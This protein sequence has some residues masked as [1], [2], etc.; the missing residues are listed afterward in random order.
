MFGSS[1]QSRFPQTK[2]FSCSEC[3]YAFGSDVFLQ[4]HMERTH[5]DVYCRMLRNRANATSA[6]CQQ[7]ASSVTSQEQGDTNEPRSYSHQQLINSNPRPGRAHQ[8]T[9]YTGEES[10]ILKQSVKTFNHLGHLNTLRRI[11]TEE[12]PFSCFAFEYLK[13]YQNFVRCQ[14]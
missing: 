14:S 3:P 7:M 10:N 4:K 12:K 8:L 11:H 6:A 5:N 13:K 2:V 1:F 9:T